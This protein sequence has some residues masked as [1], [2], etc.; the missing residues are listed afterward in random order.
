MCFK[1]SLCF[2]A[3]TKFTESKSYSNTANCLANECRHKKSSQREKN[4]D[5]HEIK[6]IES[7]SLSLVQPR[8]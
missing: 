6:F 5:M 2:N 3:A 8:I 1:F 7:L 4:I